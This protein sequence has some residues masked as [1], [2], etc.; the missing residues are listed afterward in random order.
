LLAPTE[1]QANH[2]KFY[3]QHRFI[4]ILSGFYRAMQ[5][6]IAQYMVWPCVCLSVRLIVI[7]PVSVPHWLNT[8]SHIQTTPCNSSGTHFP[9]LNIMIKFDCSHLQTGRKK[10]VGWVKIGDFRPRC[11]YISETVQVTME[12]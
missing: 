11:R 1:R 9:T 3:Y 7:K 12:G 5:W 10:Q 6:L 4:P 8:G 2:S